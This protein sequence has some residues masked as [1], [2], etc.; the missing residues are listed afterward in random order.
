MRLVLGE[1]LEDAGVE[2]LVERRQVF[3]CLADRGLVLAH[4]LAARHLDD[5]VERV[6]EGGDLGDQLFD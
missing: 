6:E 2:V 3:L 4:V 1:L 5:L